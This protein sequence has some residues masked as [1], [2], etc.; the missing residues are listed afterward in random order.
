ML[1]TME[2]MQRQGYRV[3]SGAKPSVIATVI[4]AIQ[5]FGTPPTS[6]Q[7]GTKIGSFKKDLK[8]WIRLNNMCGSGFGKDLET[9][10]ITASDDL[11]D[12]FLAMKSNKE[13]F[14][15]FRYKSLANEELLR[16]LFLDSLAIGANVTTSH[17]I[18]IKGTDNAEDADA[19]ADDEPAEEELYT[20]LATELN[21]EQRELDTEEAIDAT[22]RAK[23]S[24][25]STSTTS[26][27]PSISTFSFISFLKRLVAD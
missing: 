11:W 9:G 25:L 16:T 14:G 10:A 27:N 2:D 7:I 23:T 3:D 6:D 4:K 22:E 12:R 15:K 21:K 18:V 19:D 20:E 24:P 26:R 17:E 5:V 8:N 1:E 13:N